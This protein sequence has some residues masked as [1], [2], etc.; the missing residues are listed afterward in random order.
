MKCAIILTCT[1]SKIGYW[2]CTTNFGGYIRQC[3]HRQNDF[4]I[5]RKT[6]CTCANPYTK[7]SICINSLGTRPGGRVLFQDYNAH[8]Y[9]KKVCMGIREWIHA[10]HPECGPTTFLTTNFHPQST[11]RTSFHRGSENQ[12]VQHKD[13]WIRFIQVIGSHKRVWWHHCYCGM[14]IMSSC[15]LGTTAC[16]WLV[17][18]ASIP[19]V[20]S[21]HHSAIVLTARLW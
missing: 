19:L 13:N 15:A 17:L 7:M 3:E 8:Y 11:A 4:D 16:K 9:Y 18:H 1:N 20:V 14:M 10:A 12:S 21:L 6:A 5:M 2:E